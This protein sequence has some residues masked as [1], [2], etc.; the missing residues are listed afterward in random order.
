MNH[1]YVIDDGGSHWYSAETEIEAMQLFEKDIGPSELGIDNVFVQQLP[2]NSPLCIIQTDIEGQPRI[3][4]LASE[5]A[6]EGK[7]CV[8]STEY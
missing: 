8:A 6:S 3:E 7:G 4:K 1:I 5:W 2:D